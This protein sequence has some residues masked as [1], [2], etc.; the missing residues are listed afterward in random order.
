MMIMEPARVWA[1]TNGRASNQRP[2]RNHA[3]DKGFDLKNSI[4]EPVGSAFIAH[5]SQAVGDGAR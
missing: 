2:S 3:T 4:N 5:R 1:V